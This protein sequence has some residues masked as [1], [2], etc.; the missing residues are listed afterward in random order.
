[1]FLFFLVFNFVP[2]CRTD[3]GRDEA[4]SGAGERTVGGRSEKAD[5][6]REA[7]GSGRNEEETVVRQLQERGHLLLLLEYKLL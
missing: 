5:R 1:M 6:V 7:T 3:Y 4:E 2:N